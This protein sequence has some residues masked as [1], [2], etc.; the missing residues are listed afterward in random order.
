[1]SEKIINKFC[2]VLLY[3]STLALVKY[4]VVLFFNLIKAL[5]GGI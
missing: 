4:V 3:F 1:M 2:N 5:G